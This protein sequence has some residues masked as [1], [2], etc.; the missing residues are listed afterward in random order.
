MGGRSVA[1]TRKSLFRA[2]PAAAAFLA[3]IGTGAAEDVKG[4]WYF[5][6]NLGVLVTTDNIRNNAALI[7]AP[8][9][10]D[11]APFTGDRGEEVSCTAGRTDTYCDPRPDELLSRQTQLE[12]TLKLDGTIG[13]GLTSS[14]SVQLDAGYYK[15]NIVN[16]DV[17]AVKDTPIS[18]SPF[19]PCLQIPGETRPCFLT[20]VKTKEQ[21]TPL[22]AGQV[23][24]I[25][26]MLSGIV[27][28]RK[29]SN[30]NPYLGAG[31]GYRHTDLKVDTAVVELNER[32]AGLHIIQTTDE[33]GPTFGRLLT[34]D[35]NTGRPAAYNNGNAPFRHLAEVSVDGGFQWHVTGGAEYFFN[36][37][38][39]VLFDARY[40]VANQEISILMNGEDQ[41]NIEL[42]TEELFRPD[43]SLRVFKNSDQAPP[44][45]Y[46]PNRPFPFRFDCDYNN[47]MRFDPPPADYDGDGRVDAC[48]VVDQMDP[49][50]I[51]EPSRANLQERLVVQGG[52]MR[53]SNFTFAFG[54]RFHF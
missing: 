28:F 6:G 40:V 22:R 47:D 15:G 24:Q 26:V 31:A 36:D 51:E 39:S 45:P 4:K 12:Q 54:V 3:G 30:F 35:P 46:D 34:R 50:L 42:Y 19:D 20:A 9:G 41:I 27:R 29:D 17:F 10:A 23:T 33:F 1:S 11:G 37:R 25:P 5:G 32:L 44:N 53:L 13:Y 21:S 8:L 18:R 43:G 52:N 38:M 48:Y 49:A 7:I 16:F 2:A 14:F